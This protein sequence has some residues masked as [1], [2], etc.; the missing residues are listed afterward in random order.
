MASRMGRNC[1]ATQSTW[2]AR[3]SAAHLEM[4]HVFPATALLYLR[5]ESLH[6]L[7]QG[8]YCEILEGPCCVKCIELHGY[9]Y[10]IWTG[11]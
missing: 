8:F 4:W 9:M 3:L 5:T 11:V 1:G 6:L 10:H 2:T 7:T